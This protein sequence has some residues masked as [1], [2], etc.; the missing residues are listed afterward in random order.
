MSLPAEPDFVLRIRQPRPQLLR[1][2]QLTSLL[3]GPFFF[4]PWV[5]RTLRFRSIQYQFDADGVTMRWGGLERREVS[6]AYARIQDIHIRANVLERWLGL[7]RLEVQTASGDAKA[8]LTLEGLPE[9]LAVRDFLY[10]RSRGARLVTPVTAAAP[11]PEAALAQV[12]L[13]IAAEL[14]LIR[15]HLAAAPSPDAPPADPP[16]ASALE[17]GAA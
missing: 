2:Y 13:D 6:L 14:R 12:L 11:E 5:L 17:A 3:W 8:E 10:D 1:Y 9:P 15:E 7:A 16:A 4:I